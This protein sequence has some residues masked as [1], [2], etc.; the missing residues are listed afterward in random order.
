MAKAHRKYLQSTKIVK[1]DFHRT[2]DTVIEFIRSEP[3]AR[4]RL[5]EVAHQGSA[6]TKE[7]GMLVCTHFDPMEP[8]SE[9]QQGRARSPRELV[10]AFEWWPHSKLLRDLPQYA[11]GRWDGRDGR[12]KN[13]PGKD[14]PYDKD[15]AYAVANHRFP[16][17]VLLTV[18][19]IRGV[20]GSPMDILNMNSFATPY[21]EQP[22][23]GE[24]KLVS[25]SDASEEDLADLRAIPRRPPPAHVTYNP[26]DLSKGI[27][28]SIAGDFTDATA[29]P[30]K[31]CAREG[32][33]KCEVPRKFAIGDNMYKAEEAS[34][35]KLM[36]CS[37]CKA[38]AYCGRE[39]QVLDWKRHKSAC[40]VESHPITT[41]ATRGSGSCVHTRGP[42]TAP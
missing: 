39:C 42:A 30:A 41:A 18:F 6:E 25:I 20:D 19:A 38:V 31:Y 40:G 9:G 10:D 17:E 5:S 28:V 2:F 26:Y 16:Y 27:G 29:V 8:G 24:V 12:P 11:P 21:V 1:V 4:L 7:R 33:V 32:C 37:K 14:F 23:T 3:R 35:V 15:F 22:G 34:R 36:Q 13:C